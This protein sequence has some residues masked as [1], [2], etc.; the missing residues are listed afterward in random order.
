MLPLWTMDLH[1]HSTKSYPLQPVSDN[2]PE[3][4]VEYTVCQVC[5]GGSFWLEI[6]HNGF[7]C[8]IGDDF[9]VNFNPVLFFILDFVTKVTVLLEYIAT[10]GYVP[11]H[12]LLI[13]LRKSQ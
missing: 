6:H 7:G 4:F 11:C 12:N 5:N 13:S 10:L 2:N 8:L 1:D 3:Q 9:Y